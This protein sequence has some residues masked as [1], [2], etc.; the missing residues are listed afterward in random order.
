M[1]Y[2]KCTCVILSEHLACASAPPAH[3][4]DL[5]KN[6]GK[7]APGSD[8][9]RNLFGGKMPDPI[10]APPCLKKIQRSSWTDKVGSS[11][12][13]LVDVIAI[14]KAKRPQRLKQR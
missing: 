4:E 6:L 1:L 9:T 7:Q 2:D 14:G 13:L 8:G 12:I 5:D 3:D 11:E 10:S